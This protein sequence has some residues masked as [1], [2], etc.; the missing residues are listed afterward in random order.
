MVSARLDSYGC[1]REVAEHERSVGDEAIAAYNSISLIPRW[2][3]SSLV[4]SI[5]FTVKTFTA[6]TQTRITFGA[7][8]IRPRHFR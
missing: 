3:S 8:L 2:L 5:A 7:M 6:E 4:S 1:T